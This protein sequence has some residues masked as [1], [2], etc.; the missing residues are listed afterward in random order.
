MHHMTKFSIII[1]QGGNT[2]HK[3]ECNNI[4]KIHGQR[5]M[6]KFMDKE[7]CKNF[8]VTIRNLNPH[9]VISIKFSSGCDHLSAMI[10]REDA[11]LA[12]SSRYNNVTSQH[13]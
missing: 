11:P 1:S 5:R 4:T 2:S 3:E 10:C 12:L 9:S 13:I 8:L 6:Q 7:E